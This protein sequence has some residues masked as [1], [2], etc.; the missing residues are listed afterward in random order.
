M[1]NYNNDWNPTNDWNDEYGQADNDFA[2]FDRFV[3]SKLYRT[4]CDDADRGDEDSIQVMQQIADVLGNVV[5]HLEHN[6]PRSRIEYEIKCMNEYV[7]R[8]GD[9]E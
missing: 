6:S 7:H 8:W 5:W 4:I 2:E 9:F 3:N 1:D